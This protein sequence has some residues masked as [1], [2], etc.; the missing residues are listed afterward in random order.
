VSGVAPGVR[1]GGLD[2]RDQE[3]G[4][5]AELD[6]GADAVFAAV[7]ERPQAEA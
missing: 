4:E 6:A 2:D 5:P 3:Q 1:G 7:V